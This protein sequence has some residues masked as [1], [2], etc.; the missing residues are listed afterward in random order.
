MREAGRLDSL[1]VDARR[2]LGD[3]GLVRPQRKWAGLTSRAAGADWLR[4]LLVC[5]LFLAVSGCRLFAAEDRAPYNRD[6]RLEQDFGRVAAGTVIEARFVVGNPTAAPLGLAL[7]AASCACEVE[8]GE[9]A[10]VA[11]G[12]TEVRL[13]VETKALAGA[14]VRVVELHTT[15]PTRPIL[16][17]VL[18]GTIVAPVLAQ[19]RVLYFGRV[20][21]G[22]RPHK[23]IVLRPGGPEIRILRVSSAS[24]RLRLKRLAT[25]PGDAA[26]GPSCPPARAMVLEVFLPANLRPGGH[27]DQL[28]VETTDALLPRYEIPVLAIVEP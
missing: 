9:T 27:E 19:P 25:P 20:A 1:A 5:V 26:T 24:G 16:H 6:A 21:S 22:T 12:H 7:G 4:I 11:G 18:R 13:R 23:Q 10:V 8:I 28:V 2:R 17:L 15:D 14:V 3:A